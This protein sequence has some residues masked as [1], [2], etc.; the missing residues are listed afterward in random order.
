MM[1][2]YLRHSGLLEASLLELSSYRP[3][4][5]GETL[6]LGLVDQTMVVCGVVLHPGA[7]VFLEH[8]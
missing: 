8:V 5:Y 7:I 6:D 3:R 1:A 4:Y 2:T